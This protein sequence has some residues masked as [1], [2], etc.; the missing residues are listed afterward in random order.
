MFS[1]IV[2]FLFMFAHVKISGGGTGEELRTKAGSC[3]PFFLSVVLGVR[4]ESG[5]N[6]QSF[7]TGTLNYLHSK[8]EEKKTIIL[9]NV[10]QF[11]MSN[12]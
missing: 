10:Y 2:Y 5:S 11:T 12:I 6:K 8:E 7:K 1:Y 3:V 9:E 4:C